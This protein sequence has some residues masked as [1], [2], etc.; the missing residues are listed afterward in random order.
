MSTFI[1]YFLYSCIT[2]CRVVL[3]SALKTNKPLLSVRRVAN[4]ILRSECKK[5]PSNSCFIEFFHFDVSRMFSCGLSRLSVDDK[6]KGSFQSPQTHGTHGFSTRRDI[7]LSFPRTF[8]TKH[9]YLEP[10]NF[11]ICVDFPN[12]FPEDTF[13]KINIAKRRIHTIP[14]RSATHERV[15]V[16]FYPSNASPEVGPQGR[17]NEAHGCFPGANADPTLDTQDRNPLD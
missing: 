10:S 11:R 4:G 12:T 16:S 9:P 7:V 6:S 1:E 14:Y 15:R 8:S 13:E 3:A 5:V 17:W 2:S